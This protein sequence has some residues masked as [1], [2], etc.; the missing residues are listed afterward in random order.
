MEV[1]PLSRPV[2]LYCQVAVVWSRVAGKHKWLA[3]LSIMRLIQLSFDVI[4]S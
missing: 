1:T 2:L 4:V 3:V